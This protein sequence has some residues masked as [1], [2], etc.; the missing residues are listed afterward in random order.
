MEKYLVNVEEFRQISSDLYGSRLTGSIGRALH[1]ALRTVQ[2]RGDDAASRE[3]N[4]GRTVYRLDEYEV[5]KRAL[6]ASFEKWGVCV[7]APMLDLGGEQVDALG[8]SGLDGGTDL[9]IALKML[10]EKYC[11]N[12]VEVIERYFTEINDHFLND[13]AVTVATLLVDFK[14]MMEANERSV[15]LYGPVFDGL[16]LGAIAQPGWMSSV[17]GSTDDLEVLGGAAL[18]FG[19]FRWQGFPCS[20]DEW[21]RIHAEEPRPGSR[22]P[23]IQRKWPTKLEP[24][25][26]FSSKQKCW[27][28]LN[29]RSAGMALLEVL[30][31]AMSRSSREKPVD[32]LA[33]E[34]RKT[35]VGIYPYDPALFLTW[36]EMKE[37]EDE[38]KVKVE[39]LSPRQE[40][41]ERRQR[42]AMQRRDDAA[43]ASCR[44]QSEEGRRSVSGRTSRVALIEAPAA[45]SYDPEA[46]PTNVH[47]RLGP[48][49][50]RHARTERQIFV[51]GSDNKKDEGA[52]DAEDR[53]GDG[54][55]PPRHGRILR[56]LKR[57]A[58][59]GQLRDG[60]S[61]AT[62]ARR[63]RRT[64][65][66]YFTAITTERTAMYPQTFLG[67]MLC[68]Q[69]GRKK[70]GLELCWVDVWKQGGALPRNKTMPCLYCKSRQHAVDA[71]CY[72]HHRCADCGLMG[73]VKAEC[74]DRAPET[75]KQM[76]LECADYGV[77]T[78][79]NPFGPVYGRFGLGRDPRTSEVLAIVDEV[80]DKLSHRA[81]T[82]G[83][84]MSDDEGFQDAVRAKRDEGAPFDLWWRGVMTSDDVRKMEERLVVRQTSENRKGIKRKPGRPRVEKGVKFERKK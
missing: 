82:E 71:C 3:G 74:R 60:V 54:R 65:K 84:L 31:R 73:H 40:L 61:E 70:H 45:L 11:C 59:A 26:G 19:Y 57:E 83:W 75:W 53:D 79:R 5:R 17:G 55:P 37:Q 76:F 21:R 29:M 4:T 28:V 39:P 62:L 49:V 30:Q 51:V 58:E 1:V 68:H 81:K 15:R 47:Y 10:S 67:P 13:R 35:L 52:G 78:G 2:A 33:H 27:I 14:I 23:E 44:E 22:M 32:F 6:K 69:C 56:Q 42:N 9:V 41:R 66:R 36:R 72:L 50:Q 24:K 43:V 16:A 63:N 38:P 77:L 18:S 46:P 12:R 7:V 64:L 34:V 20:A 80:R 8:V 48:E 25:R